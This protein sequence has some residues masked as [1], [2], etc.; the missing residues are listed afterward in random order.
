M[1]EEV[2]APETLLINNN[3]QD[4]EQ[5]SIILILIGMLNWTIPYIMY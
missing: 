5:R 1:T 2:P 4:N 3:N